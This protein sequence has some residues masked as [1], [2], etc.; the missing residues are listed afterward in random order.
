MFVLQSQKERKQQ[1]NDNCEEGEEKPKQML[2]FPTL[3]SRQR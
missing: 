1:K 3:W 2:F